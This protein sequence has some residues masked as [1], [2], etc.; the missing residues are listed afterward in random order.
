MKAGNESFY[1]LVD[2]FSS[3]YFGALMLARKSLLF[4][5]QRKNGMGFVLNSCF[6]NIVK[7]R[8]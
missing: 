1:A 8:I 5:E 2:G 6:V 4:D 3:D 7:H